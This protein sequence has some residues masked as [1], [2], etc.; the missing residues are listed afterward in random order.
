M[1]MS[2]YVQNNSEESGLVAAEPSENDNDYFKLPETIQDLEYEYDADMELK[3]FRD[4]NTKAFLTED[5]EIVQLIA[6]EPVHY[7]DS[8]GVWHDID[9]NVKA[10]ASGYEVSE[11]T[12][13][14]A[15]APEAGGGVI[16]QP[17]EFVDPIVTGIA[18]MLITLDEAGIA[19]TPYDAGEATGGVTVSGNSIR[20]S[21]GQGFDLDYLVEQ[22]QVKQILV[23]REKP[24]L[25]DGQEWFGLAEGLRLPAGYALYSGD[26]E[27]GTE[28]YQTQDALQVRNIETGELFVEIPVPTIIEPY[29]TE[30]YIATFFVQVHGNHVIL[31][32]MVE[33][34]WIL[35]DDRV[36]PLGIDPT[37]QVSSAA[38]GYCYIYY[39]YCY[40]STYRYHYRYYSTYYYVPWH[41]Y[42]FTSSNA[43]PS[44]ANISQIQWKKYMS[45][46]YGSSVTFTVSVLEGCGLD[47]RYNYGIST[48]SCNG[49]PISAS[50]L[51]SNYGGTASR[52]MV[53]AIGN[54]PSAGTVS[55]S[56][57]GWKTVTFCNSAT[58]C[59]A[60]SGGVSH[61]T[62]AQTNTATV[63]IGERTNTSA[64]VYTYA[65][66]SG[67][68]NSYIA[69]T[70][71][72]GTDADA[73]TADF[74][75]YDGQASYVEGE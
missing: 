59:A 33:A 49:N 60:T 5:G 69:I 18:P 52:S 20:Y 58:A 56:G 51:T 64:Y 30:A 8:Y 11:N 9:T 4:A 55:S 63:G 10:T 32:T 70:Y 15:F 6:N 75:K 17:N 28:V 44:G 45:Y 66:A 71:T 27:I 50:Y 48:N 40:S 62:S 73:P 46:A 42:T 54:S 57:T 41:K 37:I 16:V 29:S 21:I 53:A 12:F 72:G 13:F 3:G 39:V 68:T 74:P 2:S 36:F 35:S 47:A 26:V 34:D 7:M 1:P 24:H 65:Y 23:V 67:T 61:I 43:L 19:P 38:G 14:T 25:L 22:T 31:Q